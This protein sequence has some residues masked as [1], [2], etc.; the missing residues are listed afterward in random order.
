[1]EKPLISNQLNDNLKKPATW[2][3]IFY[4]LVFSVIVSVVSSLLWTVM[5]L[6]IITSLLTGSSNPHILGF[7]RSL[8]AYLYHI[9]LYLTFNTEI[10]PF[11]FSQWQVTKQFDAVDISTETHD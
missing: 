9:T 2:E 10:L 11:P 5:L 7:S 6:Q 3:R 1:M 4:M 8:A